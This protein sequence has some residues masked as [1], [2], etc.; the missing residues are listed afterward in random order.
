[1]K[2]I[3]W[4]LVEVA[5]R[6]LEPDEREA[7]SGDFVESGETA[8]Q[9]LRDV[10]GLVVRRQAEL[11]KDWR[12]W[13][14]LLGLVVPLGVLLSLVSRMTADFSSIYAWMYLNNWT[15]TYLTSAGARTDL[16]R[17]G[18]G[19]SLNYLA[20]VC[21]SWTGG[22]VLGFWS[23]RR[24]AVNVSLFCVTLLLAELLE[25][26]R[27]LGHWLLLPR[28][29]EQGAQ[30]IHSG[31]YSLAFYRVMFPLIVQ[32]ILVILPALWGVRQGLRLVSLPI[33]R[34]TILWASV[35]AAVTAL[36]TE[37]SVWWQVR[38]WEASPAQLPHLPSLLP[39]ALLGPLGY[40]LATA[41][42]STRHPAS[43]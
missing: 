35:L 13:L 5:A 38:T 9:A 28:P 27:Y 36:L 15:W 17:Y 20:L 34:R 33:L 40:W 31:V 6:S 7:V 41:R 39:V 42:R 21:W 30:G 26:P 12:P 14:C 32:M 37:N 4:W 29:L 22:F 24:S 1:M 19:V 8:G 18:A 2:R 3:A 11:W 16:I 25:A 43:H 10:L 23:R